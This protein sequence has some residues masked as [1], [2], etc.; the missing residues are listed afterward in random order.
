MVYATPRWQPQKKL[1]GKRIPPGLRRWL[2]EEHSLTGRLK[3][4][5]PGLFSLRLLVQRSGRPLP[6]ERTSLKLPHAHIAMIRQVQLLCGETPLVYA[7]SVIP[8]ATRN[9]AH[10]QLTHLGARPLADVL[11]ASQTMQR[12]EMEFA[13][14][15][16]GQQLHAQ[17]VEALGHRH[18]EIWG[19]RSLFRLKNKPLLV[20]EVFSPELAEP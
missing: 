13:H 8:L 6:D 20:T 17:A 3:R 5:C 11:F 7:R 10:R 4:L 16:A 9:G 12:G 14:L 19:R 1:F 2:S 15:Q 18:G